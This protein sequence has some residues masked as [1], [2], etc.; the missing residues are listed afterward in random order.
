VGSFEPYIAAS[1]QD[2]TNY[3]KRIQGIMY[4]LCNPVVDIP[5]ILKMYSDG[6]IK[7]DELITR[8]YDLSEIN[9]GFEDMHAGKNIR[10]VLVH[11][12]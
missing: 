3:A 4:G 6:R 5:R 8:R 7:L 12:H 2:F 1:P 11:K 9:E 10:G